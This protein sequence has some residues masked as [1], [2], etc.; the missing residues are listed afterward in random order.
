MLIQILQVAKE[1]FA[2][3]EMTRGASV[4]SLAVQ[5]ARTGG[6]PDRIRALLSL[7]PKDLPEQ[8]ILALLDA[9]QSDRDVADIRAIYSQKAEA[10]LIRLGWT[11]NDIDGMKFLFSHRSNNAIP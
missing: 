4:L 3:G 6:Q 7:E 8:A 1:H 11:Q 10:E 5:E 2:K 9:T